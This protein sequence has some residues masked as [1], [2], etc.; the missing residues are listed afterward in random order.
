MTPS[1]EAIR[2][3]GYGKELPEVRTIEALLLAI[4]PEKVREISRWVRRSVYMLGLDG[5]FE[6]IQGE[7]KEAANREQREIDQMSDPLNQEDAKGYRERLHFWRNFLSMRALSIADE[8][9]RKSVIGN[10]NARFRAEPQPERIAAEYFDAHGNII[11]EINKK[12][13]LDELMDIIAF[14]DNAKYL[15][16]ETEERKFDGKLLEAMRRNAHA[17]LI[18]LLISGDTDFIE[19]GRQFL[20][21]ADYSD[22]LDRSPGALSEGRI[23]KKSAGMYLGYAVLEKDSPEFNEKFAGDLNLARVRPESL[24]QAEKLLE[25]TG[26]M[27]GRE[28]M[29]RRDEILQAQ[30]TVDHAKKLGVQRLQAI[31]KNVL[32]ENNSFFIGSELLKELISHNQERLSILTVLKYMDEDKLNDRNF[33]ADVEKRIRE[34]E[35]PPHLQR[36][37][38]DLY[39]NL[40]SKT[41]GNPV[42]VRSSSALEDQAG[43]SFA[44]MYESRICPGDDFEKFLEAIKTVYVSVFTPK[45]MRYRKQKGLIDFDEAMGL[46]VQELNGQWHGRY[47]FPDLSGVALSHAPQSAGPD[48]S[49]GMM[50]IVAGLGEKVVKSGG[51]TVWFDNPNFDYRLMGGHPYAQ[52]DI[53]VFDRNDSTL[54]Y[55]SM[56]EVVKGDGA[57]FDSPTARDIFTDINEMPVNSNFLG[58]EN[59][60][61]T[62]KGLVDGNPPPLPLIIRYYV[63]KL[64]QALGYKVDIEFTASRQKNGSYR[65]RLVQC[66]PQN[67]AENLKPANMPADVP[68]ERVMIRTKT[69]LSNGHAENIRYMV[70]IP[71]EVY[72]S[73]HP[74]QLNHEERSQLHQYIAKFNNIMKEKDY[75]IVSPGRWGDNPL[76]EVGVY[77]VAGDYDRTAGIIEVVGGDGHWKDVPPSAGT[78]DFQLIIERGIS[79]FGMNLSENG[80]DAG[81]H[82][83]KT[84]LDEGEN[85]LARFVSDVP[86]RLA[87]WIRVLDAEE[88]GRASTGKK[89]DWR[90]NIA[91]NNTAGSQEAVVYMAQEGKDAPIIGK[92]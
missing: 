85:M 1:D 64:E 52:D 19:V 60:N 66:R 61:A 11:R 6:G 73:G 75:V 9:K 92:L 18:D 69:S 30:E 43:A 89:K 27:S 5:G 46:L 86:E 17:S 36:Q 13:P 47:F 29:E 74:D 57:G 41:G 50:T 38:K 3:H 4:N 34:A 51:K 58:S 62:F 70:Y 2:L 78:H 49:K 42:I 15:E 26:R 24:K 39:E 7:A 56:N 88:I 65:V 82:M 63:Q 67:I 14:T 44:G 21:Y 33:V 10:I 83:A 68:K 87:R 59:L 53:C 72:G 20:T 55:V 25:K 84:Q 12:T 79:T 81:A 28:K 22:M 45:V 37:L 16:Y 54:K 80:N 31:L 48:P 40:Q 8:K 23:G 77:A 35:F 32:E 71:P 91:M 90:F 76:S